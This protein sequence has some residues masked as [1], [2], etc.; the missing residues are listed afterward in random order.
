MKAFWEKDT[1][2]TRKIYDDVGKYHQQ[3]KEKCEHANE[4]DDD[5]F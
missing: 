4:L 5:D 3:L 1:C 2:P